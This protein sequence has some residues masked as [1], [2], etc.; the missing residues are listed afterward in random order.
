MTLEPFVSAQSWLLLI[1]LCSQRDPNSPWQAGSMRNPALPTNFTVDPRLISSMTTV[2]SARSYQSGAGF[3]LSPREQRMR[4]EERVN[5][6]PRRNICPFFITP[7]QIIWNFIVAICRINGPFFII[8]DDIKSIVDGINKHF[9]RISLV[10]KPPF[11]LWDVGRTIHERLAKLALRRRVF[12]IIVE[13]YR[14]YTIHS[15]ANLVDLFK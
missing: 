12:V 4:W 6:P 3:S 15:L 10:Q 13:S 5:K 9:A 1:C 8:F 11:W 7:C 2:Y 14:V